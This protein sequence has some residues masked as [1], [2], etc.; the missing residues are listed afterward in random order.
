[1]GKRGREKNIL[2]LFL[3]DIFTHFIRKLKEKN[4]KFKSLFYQKYQVL[5]MY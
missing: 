1:M 5:F 3:I 4:R 2:S